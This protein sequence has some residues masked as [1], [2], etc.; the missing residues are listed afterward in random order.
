MKNKI[1]IPLLIIGVLAA[2]FSFKY[3]GRD[4]STTEGRREVILETVMAAV[5]ANHYS[6]REINDTFSQRVFQKITGE[7]DYGKLFFTQKDINKLKKYEFQIDDEIKNGSVE[8]FDTLDEIFRSRIN[9]VEKF[10]QEILKEPFTFKDD[11]RMELN[12]D[13][14][15]FAADDAELTSSSFFSN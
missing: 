2:F 7:L 9:D 12:A 15:P 6:P 13:K 11:D 10:Y 14:L 3:S 8:F 5:K 1:L 4:A